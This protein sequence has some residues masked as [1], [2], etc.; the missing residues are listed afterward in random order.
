MLRVS[1]DSPTQA[2]AGRERDIV[3]ACNPCNLTE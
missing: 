1:H 3:Y 2:R